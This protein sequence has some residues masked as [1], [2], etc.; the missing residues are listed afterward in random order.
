MSGYDPQVAFAPDSLQPDAEDNAPRTK[1]DLGKISFG[2]KMNAYLVLDS[3]RDLISINGFGTVADLYRLANASSQFVDNHW[4][5]TD[6]AEFDIKENILGY[7]P[8]LP[9]PKLLT[10]TEGPIKA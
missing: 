1:V 2:F 10:N 6:G 3:L 8:A 4:G 5:W 7:Y 9:D